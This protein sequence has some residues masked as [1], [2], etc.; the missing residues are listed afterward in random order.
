MRLSAGDERTTLCRS[1]FISG[2]SHLKQPTVLARAPQ[3]RA[4][5]CTPCSVTGCAECLAAEKDRRRGYSLTL[6]FCYLHFLLGFLAFRSFPSMTQV[7]QL[8][9]SVLHMSNLEFDKVDSEQGE[10]ASISDR[11]VIREHPP[12]AA[13][14]SFHFG[15]FIRRQSELQD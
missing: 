9:A 13:L 7:W 3:P 1:L 4:V 11:E 14:P 5:L 8:L 2:T 15:T 6:W 12:P 10:V